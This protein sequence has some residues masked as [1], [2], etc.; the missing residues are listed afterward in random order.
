MIM[1]ANFWRMNSLS[2]FTVPYAYIDN[3]SYLADNLLEQNKVSLKIKG[4]FK[5]K[6]SPYR[7]ILCRVKKRDTGRF[8]E[9]LEKLKDK[10][11]LFGYRDYESVCDDFDRLIAEEKEEKER[12]KQRSVS[13]A[14]S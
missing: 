8:E 4:E 13:A 9:A 2:I 1:V 7:I 11:L 14:E 10:M 3:S 5:R 12:Q 6:D